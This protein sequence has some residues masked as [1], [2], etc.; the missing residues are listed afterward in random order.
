ME[1][2]IRPFHVIIYVLMLHT[3]RIVFS[4]IYSFAVEDTRL[5]AGLIKASNGGV[6]FL[7]N[8]NER[9]LIADPDEACV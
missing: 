5:K 9:W 7:D 2:E 6:W 1:H 4:Q 8:Q 3:L